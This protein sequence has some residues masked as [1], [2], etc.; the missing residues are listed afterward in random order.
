MLGLLQGY[1]I[2]MRQDMTYAK[3]STLMGKLPSTVSELF[4]PNKMQ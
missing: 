1:R 4:M 2:V 3:Y